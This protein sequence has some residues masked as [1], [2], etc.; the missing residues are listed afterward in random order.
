M[1]T[2]GPSQ[3]VLEFLKIPGTNS[4]LQIPGLFHIQIAA[5]IYKAQL[6]GILMDVADRQEA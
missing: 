2:L 3:S 6:T 5:N 1:Q 4:N